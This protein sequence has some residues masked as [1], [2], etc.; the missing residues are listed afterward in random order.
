M[1]R[2]GIAGRAR[3]RA[4]RKQRDFRASVRALL[5]CQIPDEELRQRLDALGLDTT[6][7]NAIHNGVFEKALRGDV[8]AARYLRDLAEEEGEKKEPSTHL[9][10]SRLSDLELR[11]L[12]AGVSSGETAGDR[13]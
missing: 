2:S 12:A 6:V 4:G 11:R 8:S 5:A 3:R 9:D 10:L 1:D 13:P 7:L